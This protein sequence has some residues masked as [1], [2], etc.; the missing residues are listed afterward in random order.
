MMSCSMSFRWNATALSAFAVESWLTAFRHRSKV[1]VKSASTFSNTMVYHTEPRQ[2]AGQNERA[3]AGDMGVCAV[4]LTC[5][6]EVEGMRQVLGDLTR[7]HDRT[8][9]IPEC[10]SCCVQNRLCSEILEAES[11]ESSGLL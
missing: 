6:S 4:T 9:L 7:T 1:F 8:S 3:R 10:I 11:R 2:S 5:G